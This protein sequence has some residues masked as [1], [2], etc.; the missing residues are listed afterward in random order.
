MAS[1]HQDVMR[2]YN[3]YLNEPN[4][5]ATYRPSM[6]SSPLNNPKTAR[7]WVHF[8]H[9]TAP[10]ISIM[11]RH[12]ASPT[13][14]F[15]GPVP[16]SQQALWSYIMPLKSL[17]HPALLQSILAISSLHIAR[18]QQSHFT[19]TFKHYEYALRKVSKAV[20]LP[21]RRKQVATLAAT[22]LLAFY[23]VTAADH[24]KWD[25][26][27]AGAAQLLKEIDFAGMTRD[28]RAYRRTVRSQKP[29][30]A[31]SYDPFSSYSYAEEDPFAEKESQVDA[32]V[33]SRLTG[34]P[35]DYDQI[36]RVDVYT[37]VKRRH[38][39]R[40]DIENFRLQCDLYWW[41]AK[42]DMYQS[43]LS[44]NRLL[45]VL[46]VLEIALS[47]INF[48]TPIERWDA[49]PPRAGLGKADA[50]YGSW[51][52]LVLLMAPMMDF[53]Y[54]D[55]RRKLQSLEA[56]GGDWRPH[57][58]FFKFVGRFAPKPPGGGGPG[59]PPSGMGPPPGRPQGPPGGNNSGQSS[60]QK[61]MYGMAPTGGPVPAPAAFTTMGD[62]PPYSGFVDDDEDTTLEEAEAEW[63]RI[64]A[65]YEY[66]ES[67]L[68]EGFA[69]L[70]PD[71]TT[72]VS[73]PFG[74]AI[75]FRSHSIAVLWAYYYVGRII[76]N[77]LHPS[78]P[79]ATMVAASTAAS[80]TARFAQTIGRIAA[81]VYYPQLYVQ[82]VGN[83][84]PNLGGAWIQ[85]TMTLFVAGIQYTDPTQ[86]DWTVSTLRGTSRVTGWQTA[87]AIAAGCE[88]AW[89]RTAAVGRGPPY[90]RGPEFSETVS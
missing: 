36:G 52:H 69:P 26:H 28:L 82:E 56:T 1:A 78:M 74:P 12:N 86:R 79:P 3:T 71:T 39:S 77:R 34:R 61:P 60:T 20:G 88:A 32:N 11:E 90:V 47:L 76:L 50:I 22:L 87:E 8:I 21:V 2:S 59:G 5:L 64:L 40:K 49:V 15:G 18:L 9:A 58:G 30:W 41:Y 29:A 51:D 13:P 85:A 24:T 75:Q 23:E 10:A 89:I 35:V 45:Y 62:S 73:S 43:M 6:G 37:K 55:R 84:N 38:L 54:R 83:L 25:R 67:Q 46:L 4:I 63:E 66:Y 14:F 42:Q 81:G 65:A 68:G 7:I 53:G 31:G 19:I 72:P 70:P 33:V 80:T 48:S 57:P 17:E 27:V 44:G 16:A